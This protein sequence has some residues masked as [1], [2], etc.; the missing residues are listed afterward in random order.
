[1]LCIQDAYTMLYAQ[2]SSGECGTLSNIQ[3]K[4]DFRSAKPKVSN[5]FNHCQELL[6]FSTRGLVLL[7]AMRLLGFS[8]VN[9]VLPAESDPTSILYQVSS[10]V[11][12][13]FWRETS[14]TSIME[15]ID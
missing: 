8:D 11:V 9:D 4:F 5:A 12:T 7:V 13:F 10:K 1:M 14:V 15:M 6:H 2:G 3:T